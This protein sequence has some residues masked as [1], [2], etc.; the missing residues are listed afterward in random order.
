[1][2]SNE[3]DDQGRK[4]FLNG[5]FE[6]ALEMFRE[7]LRRFPGDEDLMLGIGMCQARL[8]NVILA[9][10]TLEALR[11][12]R[13]DW[14]DVLLGLTDAYLKLGRVQ[15][16]REAAA[17]ATKSEDDPSFI[18]EVA[19]LFFDH[20][21][22][23][24]AEALYRRAGEQHEPYPP[25]HLGLGACLHRQGNLV[26]A[27]KAIREAIKI[28]AEYWP[29]CQYLGNLL[30][31][32]DRKQEARAVLE[33]VPLDVTWH[34]LAL[35][36]LVTMSP[37]EQ[38]KRRAMEDMLRRSPTRRGARGVAGLIAQIEKGWDDKKS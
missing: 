15:A 7:A 21:R 26:A 25:A 8:G 27:E 16:A 34:R 2:D 17:E 35:E 14:G 30:Y 10:E 24:E 31:E 28:D 38:P 36:R 20:R 33:R 32:L 18:H 13:P 37:Q 4:L 19:R 12:K 6:E 9:V 11:A 23:V 29:A 1:M 3:Y 5:R 22:Y